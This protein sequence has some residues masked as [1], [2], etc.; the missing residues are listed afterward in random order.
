MKK[1]LILGLLS[2]ALVLAV[3][4]LFAAFEAHVINVTARIENALFV[5]PE[6]LD[7][8]TVFPQEHLNT[9]FFVN[10]SESFSETEQTRVGTIEYV[11]KQKPK[12]RVDTPENRQFCHDNEPA[13]PADPQDPYYETCYP[14]LCPYLSKHPDSIPSTGPN[15]NN[16]TEIPP[17][18]DPADESSWALGKLV[19]FPNIDNDPAD[20]WT[21]DLAVP[22]FEEACAQ[23]WD[24]FV[25]GLNPDAGDPA[26]YQLP[27][28][29]ESEI[30]GCDLWVEVTDIY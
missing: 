25:L 8:G 15:A 7:Y 11:I 21:I 13:N 26:Q 10:F 9:S 3:M 17:F 20:T 24:N 6:S 22:C 30:F 2:V 12:P 4:P 5:H 1:K 18:H 19:K 27:P 29:L 28:T 16:D 14:L 23:D